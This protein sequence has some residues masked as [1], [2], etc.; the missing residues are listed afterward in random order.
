MSPKLVTILDKIIRDPAYSSFN[1]LRL[2]GSNH[3]LLRLANSFK[4]F[5]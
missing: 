3:V 5:S 1:Y 4:H 2:T